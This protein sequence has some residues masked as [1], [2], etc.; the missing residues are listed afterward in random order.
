MTALMTVATSAGG[1]LK[2]LISAMYF[3]SKLS[4]ASYAAKRAGSAF[5]SSLSASAASFSVSSLSLLTV[6]VSTS[7]NFCFSSAFF[8]SF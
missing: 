8:C 7:M 4:R 3:L 1:L 2:D 6:T 5:L